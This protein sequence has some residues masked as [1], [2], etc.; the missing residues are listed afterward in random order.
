[1]FSKH[2][3]EALSDAVFAIAMTLLILD[4]KVPTELGTDTLGA[5]LRHKGH[6]WISFAV[7]FGIA[8]LFWVLQHRVFELLENVGG[9]S[10]VLTFV[11]LGFVTTLPFSTALWGHHISQPLASVL[12]FGNQFL[13]ALTLAAKLELARRQRHVRVGK[14]LAH[15]RLRLWVMCGVQGTACLAAVLLPI[16]YLSIFPLAFTIV[17]KRLRESTRKRTAASAFVR[18]AWRVHYSCRSLLR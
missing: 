14:D 7:T 2:R 17:G 11:F 5:A 9:G 10:T 3:L 4:L 15:L 16:Q 8:S 18:K 12:Y 6:E 1:M 13:I